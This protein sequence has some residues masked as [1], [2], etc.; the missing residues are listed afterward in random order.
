MNKPPL[1]RSIVSCSMVWYGSTVICFV[2]GS[3][4]LSLCW[5]TGIVTIWAKPLSP[6]SYE[7]GVEREWGVHCRHIQDDLL[8]WA[9]RE[10]SVSQTPF[11]VLSHPTSLK[12]SGRILCL[13]SYHTLF[14][15][16][17]IDPHYKPLEI[18]DPHKKSSITWLGNSI[19][20]SN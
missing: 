10:G 5:E 9:G 1:T 20:S 8:V 18:D 4:K 16:Q 12:R 6:P 19:R 17:A 15:F 3:L 2:L 11:S 14:T 13:R 7:L